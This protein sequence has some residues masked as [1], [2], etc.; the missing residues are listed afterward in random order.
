MFLFEGPLETTTEMVAGYTFVFVV[1]GIYIASIYIRS[2]NL[3]RDL[4][5][6]E[7]LEKDKK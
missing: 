7:S 4:E 3:R 6:L 1:M 2:R 5:T